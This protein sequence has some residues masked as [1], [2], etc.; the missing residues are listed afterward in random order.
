MSKGKRNFE[1]QEWVLVDTETNGLRNPI[2]VIELGA[3]LMKGWEPLGEPYV[4]KINHGVAISPEAERVHGISADLLERDGGDPKQVYDL[5]RNYVADR[6]VASYNLAFDWD[7]VLLREWERLHIPPIGNRGF[8]IYRLAQRLLDPIDTENLKLQTLR[9][10]YNLPIRGAHSAYGDVETV[11]DLI[12]AVIFPLLER[13]EL[14]TYDGIIQYIDS[15]WYPTRLK[16]GKFKGRMVTEAINDP[17]FRDWLVWLKN[18]DRKS[19]SDM[20]RW[21]LENLESLMDK[22]EKNSTQ[23]LSVDSKKKINSARTDKVRKGI[24]LYHDLRQEELEML[25]EAARERLAD[26]EVTYTRILNKMQQVINKIF[27]AVADIS[28]EIDRLRLRVKYKKEYLNAILGMSEKTSEEIDDQLRME[29]EETEKEYNDELSFISDS[30]S[31]GSEELSELKRIFRKLS[32]IFH[33]DRYAN[34]SQ[35]YDLYLEATKIINKARDEQNIDLLRS[36]VDNPEAFKSS[37][38]SEFII[39]N[40]EVNPR[41]VYQSLQIRIVDILSKIEDLKSDPNYELEKI[42]SR[43]PEYLD[44]IIYEKTELLNAEKQMLL[45]EIEEIDNEISNFE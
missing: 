43:R 38:S 29:T 12:S 23:Y 40:L 32:A 1:H 24:V 6:P 9:Q 35:S 18:S 25:V 11:I 13:N 14:N 2:Y 28:L 10:Y 4:S 21:Y 8:C 15:E 30:K 31:L 22:F 3:Q 42:V 19:S 27:S 20:G 33:P 26:L 5:F 45:N 34:D 37:L 36:I 16:F 17:V 44:K 39:E 41:D 7:R